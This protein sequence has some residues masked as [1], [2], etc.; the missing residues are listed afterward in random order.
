MGLMFARRRQLEDKKR[1]DSAAKKSP[2]DKAQAENK[3][4]KADA[5]HKRTKK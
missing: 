1:K 4:G 5:S 2:V 3:K